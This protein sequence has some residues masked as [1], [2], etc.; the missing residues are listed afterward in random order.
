[1]AN[2]RWYYRSCNFYMKKI[3]VASKNPVKINAAREAFKRMFPE[4]NFIVEGASVDS[5]VSDQPMSDEETYRGAKNRADNANKE[6]PEAD[7]WVGMEGG[8]HNK[9]KDIEAFAWMVVKSK[10]GKYGEARTGTFFLPKEIVRLMREENME[11]GHASDVVFNENNSKQKSA[12]IG[13]LTKDLITRTDYYVHA[14]IMAL[15]PFKNVHLY[16]DA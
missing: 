15:I 16:G 1:M 8:V 7:F 10:N 6:F 13:L 3:L 4:E 9:D 11:L 14:T 12:T 5:G 2:P